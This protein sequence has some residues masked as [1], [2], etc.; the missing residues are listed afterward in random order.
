MVNN[1]LKIMWKKAILTYMYGPSMF[2][3]I[4]RKSLQIKNCRHTD[5]DS[6]GIPSVQKSETIILVSRCLVAY[7][8]IRMQ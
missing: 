1:Q 6:T 2:L 3:D 4:M 7:S 5:I 8:V